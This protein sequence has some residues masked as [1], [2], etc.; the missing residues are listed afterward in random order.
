[1]KALSRLMSE[2]QPVVEVPM[3]VIVCYIISKNQKSRKN[4]C[5][6]LLWENRNRGSRETW[7]F[8]AKLKSS[9]KIAV[10]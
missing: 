1:M 2:I 5:S 7:T 4:H 10:E 9:V 8:S 3:F 6:H